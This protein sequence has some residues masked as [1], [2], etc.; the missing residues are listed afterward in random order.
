MRY[1]ALALCAV[2]L[3]ASTPSVSIE[4]K[5]VDENGV[6]IAGGRVEVSAPGLAS[7]ISATSDATGAFHLGLE[8]AGVYKLRAEREGFFVF[9][10]QGITLHDGA[11][12]LSIT[13]NHLKDFAES[14]NVNYSPVDIDVQQ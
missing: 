2:T 11:Q 13:L 10:Q 14:V 8:R 3:G 1:A 7:P 4:G 6:A 9:S 12:Q 5:L